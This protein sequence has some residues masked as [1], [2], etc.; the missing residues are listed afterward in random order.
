M[1]LRRVIN[2]I[3]LLVILFTALSK[4]DAQMNLKG[5]GQIG[6]INIEG[7]LYS[8]SHVN[9]SYYDQMNFTINHQ[10]LH[11]W[12]WKFQPT[13]FNDIKYGGF[14]D[15][16]GSYDSYMSNIFSTSYRNGNGQSLILERFK[17]NLAAYGQRSTYQVEK[18]SN[19]GNL[20]IVKQNPGYGYI[21][22]DFNDAVDNTQNPPVKGKHCQPGIDNYLPTNY[23]AKGLYEN[24]EQTNC[25]NDAINFSDI[26]SELDPPYRFYVKP[27]IKIPQNEDPNKDV[28]IV[29]IYGYDGLIIGQPITLKVRDF[30]DVNGNYDGSYQ[31]IFFQNPPIPPIYPLSVRGDSLNRGTRGAGT[32]SQVDY[33]IK[34]CG[35]VDV[36]VDYVRVD[37]EWAH[38]L[39]N[40]DPTHPLIDRWDFVSKINSEASYFTTTSNP[41]FGLFYSDEFQNNNVDCIAEVKRLIELASAGKTTLVPMLNHNMLSGRNNIDGE[42]MQLKNFIKFDDATITDLVSRGLFKDFVMHDPYAFKLNNWLRI[43]YPHNLTFDD[44]L[45][46][47]NIAALYASNHANSSTEYNEDIQ[48]VYETFTPVNNGLNDSYYTSFMGS[49][50]LLAKALQQSILQH[51]DFVITNV[52]QAHSFESS[53]GYIL[54][55]PTNEEISLQA[56]LGLAYGAKQTMYYQFQTSKWDSKNARFYA[57]YGLLNFDGTPRTSN[58]YKYSN[59]SHQD[60]WNSV[61][62]LNAKIKQIYDYMYP[63]NNINSHLS[64]DDTRTVNTYPLSILPKPSTVN[65]NLGLPV[66]YISDLQSVIRDPSALTYNLNLQDE[67]AKR[68]WELGFFKNNPSNTDNTEQFSKYFIA[69]NK[70]CTPESPGGLSDG[71]VRTL[72]LKFN[73]SELPNFNNWVLID[74]LTNTTVATINKNS[75]DFYYAGEFQPGEGRLFKLAP[76][77]QE[78]GTFVCNEDFG[79]VSLNC[80]GNV[81]T[82]AKNLTV[83][84]NTTIEFNVDCGITAENCAEVSFDG[85]GTKSIHLQGKNQSK[86]FGITAN[87]ISNSVIFNNTDFRNVK[88]GWAI[89]I[90]NT[91][92]A[93]I[94]QND[95][96]LED[97]GTGYNLGAIIVNNNSISSGQVY[98]MNNNIQVKDVTAAIIVFNSAGTGGEGCLSYNNISTS[99]N[100]RI[101]IFLSNR[102]SEELWNNTI[103]G[104][105]EGIH[106]YCSNVKLK[107]NTVL[108]NKNGSKGIYGSVWSSL[109]LG[110][111]NEF[112]GGNTFTNYGNDCINL[113]VDKSF[114][115]SYNGYNNYN[116]LNNTNSY[117]LY[118]YGQ[119]NCFSTSPTNSC[120]NGPNGNAIYDLKDTMGTPCSLQEIPHLCNTNPN[121]ETDFIVSLPFNI[122]DTVCKLTGI[123]NQN[124]TN[125]QT[126]SKNFSTNIIKRNYDSAII[127]GTE[128]LSSYSDSI[129]APEIITKLYLA[130]TSIDSVGLKVQSLKTFYEQLIINHSQNISI[131]GPTNYYIQKCKVFLKQ[132]ESALVGFEDIIQ[133]NPY[134]FD[135]LLASWDYAATVLLIDTTIGSGGLSSKDELNELFSSSHDLDYLIDSLRIKRI[136]KYDTYDKSVFSSSDRKELIKKTG[137]VLIDERNKQINKVNDL[138]KEVAKGVGKKETKA[139]Q[140]LTEL[141][142]LNEVVKV[143]KPKNGV[144][145]TK[146]ISDDMDKIFKG[147]SSGENKEANSI[148]TTYALYQ[149]YP[150]PFNPTTKIV[151]DIPKDAKVKL[152]IYDILGREMKTLVNNEFRSAGKYITEF[153]GSNLAS[154]IYFARILV[155]EGKDFMAVKKLV[156]LK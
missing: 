93:V 89:T 99:G 40:P 21:Y 22:S 155:N 147:N 79:G 72:R 12:D 7:A 86:W 130:S 81:Y 128:L 65:I 49:Y 44:P 118:G 87:N 25:P 134:S 102:I 109:N 60:K 152:V 116:V 135:G 35:Q 154:G 15:L 111:F 14:Y 5:K 108:S 52:I 144:E 132:Y 107:N 28:V 97:A 50:R 8:P 112:Y 57:N 39:F 98:I 140:E 43:R 133:Q 88:Y 85:G 54:R 150:N 31:E 11:Q 3:I 96:Y 110:Y 131:V 104:F 77:M 46:N 38:F 4:L 117:N 69:L 146:I 94:Q 95:F 36:W 124:P 156:L 17:T 103:S 61:V 136:L 37:D 42:Q 71:D 127:Q 123:N 45:H 2:G 119:L 129:Y 51:K 151:Y 30:F 90:R 91:Q 41:G 143:K 138:Q 126:L 74:P 139:K 56:Y 27:R 13:G 121:E 148:P 19:N 24:N 125:L 53:P 73:P 16:I 84:S 101:G 20:E 105:S 137:N 47:L 153:N 6:A 34:W 80:K 106:T 82:G 63:A 18:F 145:Y 67:N 68:Y 29:E 120:F 59:N 55:E 92:W 76:V 64:Y 83:R 114:F 1:R 48:N 142:T 100:G 23:I 62:N 141:R 26:K 10:Y 58:V 9:Y 149:N 32:V 33:R 75:T 70:R 66:K 115:I 113:Q 78:G 122:I